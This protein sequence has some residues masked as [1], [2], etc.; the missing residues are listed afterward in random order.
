MDFFDLNALKAEARERLSQAPG[1]RMLVLIYLGVLGLLSLSSS[2]LNLYLSS[3]ISGTG[4]LGGLGLRSVLQ[5]AQSVLS[6]INTF[7]GPFWQAG[8]VFCVIA[9]VRGQ[10]TGPRDLTQ[11]FH[12]FGRILSYTLNN[13]LLTMLLA[14]GALLGASL[15]FSASPWGTE[16]AEAMGPVLTDPNLFLADGT[17]NMDAIPLEALEIM[18]PPMALFFAGLFLPAQL[19]VNYAFRMGHYLMMGGNPMTGMGAMILSWKLTRGHRMKFVKLDLSYWW[20]YLLL[21]LAMALG[22]LDVILSGLGITLPV[23]AT[24]LFFLTMVLYLLA[25]LA[26]SL[27]KK[28]EVDAASMI[29]CENIMKAHS[30]KLRP[31]PVPG[32]DA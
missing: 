31:V 18:L 22:Y 14:F 4:G 15:I 17:V 13:A 24:A 29:L 28:C 27:W 21:G 26:V 3:Q 2:A 7:F 10:Q 23:D 8:F 12:R 5:T 1:H 19:F 32:E 6:Y 9:I 16:F 20:Y 11:G 25:E 30:A